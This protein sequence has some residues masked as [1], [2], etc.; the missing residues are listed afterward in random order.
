MLESWRSINPDVLLA[1]LSQGCRE[2][3]WITRQHT[4]RGWEITL[5]TTLPSDN[6]WQHEFER[7]TPDVFPMS[8]FLEYADYP[9]FLS[10][11]IQSRQVDAV[12]ITASQEAYRLLPYI[13]NR[14]PQ[15]PIL[16]YLH[17]P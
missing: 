11:L 1:W 4:Q 14:F 6:P 10:Y 5:A 8:N 12:L 16:D 17:L 3:L 7:I 15:L 2:I 13:R 9:R